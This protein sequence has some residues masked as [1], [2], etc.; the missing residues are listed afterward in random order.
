MTA[1]LVLL[2]YGAL[3]TSYAIVGM[4]FLKFWARTR[5]RLF[6]LFA[7]A[8]WLLALHRALAVVTYNWFADS[9]WLY[10]LRL[11]AFVVILAAIIDKNRAR[12]ALSRDRVDG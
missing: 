7:A 3:A 12:G 4:F 6:A 5:D 2:V 1:S 8:F 10:V 11:V 9:T